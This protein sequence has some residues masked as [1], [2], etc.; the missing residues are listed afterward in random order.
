[1][2]YVQI[3]PEERKYMQHLIISPPII[4]MQV[5]HDNELDD[6][7]TPSNSFATFLDVQL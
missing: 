3:P 1:M 5:L 7:H 4:P 2:L 6:V